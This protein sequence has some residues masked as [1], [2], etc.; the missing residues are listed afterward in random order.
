MLCFT[1]G[2]SLSTGVRT[3][4]IMEV[5]RRQLMFGALSSGVAIPSFGLGKIQ[6]ERSE[7]VEVPQVLP[8]SVFET[9]IHGISKKTHDNHLV[10]W[11]GYANKTNEIRKALKDLNRTTASPNQIYSEMRALKANYA[12]AWGGYINHQVYFSVLG[13][14]SAPDGVLLDL[15]KESFGSFEN[16]ERDFRATCAA[17]RGWVMM[18]IDHQSY[19]IINMVG[20]AQDTFPLWGHTLILACDVYEHAYYLDFGRDRGK[21]VDAFLKSIDWNQVNKNLTYSGE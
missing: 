2:E 21:Y 4:I 3:E 13:K 8:E 12:F 18:A 6:P 15:I 20:D 16:W 5:T 17:S 7:F 11:Q 1:R 14:G 9:E 10:L 19:R